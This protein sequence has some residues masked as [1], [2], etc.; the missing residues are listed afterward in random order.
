MKHSASRTLFDL[1][2]AARGI[3]AAPSRTELDVERLR[4]VL[5]DSF[6]L[7]C[8]ADGRANIRFAGTRLCALFGRDIKGADL[9]MLWNGEDRAS[10]EDFLAA[11]HEDALGVVAGALSLQEPTE[12]LEILMLPLRQQVGMPMSA[13]GVI[14]RRASSHGPVQTPL[15]LTSWRTVGAHVDHALRRKQRMVRRIEAA[16]GFFVYEGFAG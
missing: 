10:F 15:R 11:M 16:R 3:A 13:V 9:R 1:W 12:H 5:A 6:V 14:T 2:D 7:T 8:E 4:P